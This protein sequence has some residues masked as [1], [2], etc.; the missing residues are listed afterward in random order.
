MGKKHRTSW[1]GGSLLMNPETDA[2][3]TT[4]E[5]AQLIPPQQAA[6][7]VGDRTSFVIE[8]IYMHFSIRRVSLAQ[9]DALG[10]MVYQSMVSEAGNL[11]V[12]A[13]DAL[14]T[15]PREYSR[16]NIMM[17]APLPVPPLL[18][19]GDL[20]SFQTDDRIITEHHEFQAMR[21]HD[22]ASQV[23][24]MTINSDISLVVRIFAQWRIL[25]G[26]TN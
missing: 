24:C 21:K 23:L 9:P 13:L 12:L 2:G 17:M 16:K 14:S 10:F 22:T 5:V 1:L 3:T 19:A 11:P 26:W 8:A 6:E 20:L 4:A 25:I 15:T 7:V 18:G